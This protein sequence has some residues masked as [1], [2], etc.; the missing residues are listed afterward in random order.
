MSRG[1][2][3]IFGFILGVLFA[4]T[5]DADPL[6]E[7]DYN[8]IYDKASLVEFSMKVRGT[9]WGICT[10]TV[11]DSAGAILL[12]IPDDQVMNV[13]GMGRELYFLIVSNKKATVSRHPDNCIHPDADDAT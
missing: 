10:I 6:T 2:C 5:L 4:A 3:L 8:A 12:F 11:K 7:A 9:E 13:T 1:V